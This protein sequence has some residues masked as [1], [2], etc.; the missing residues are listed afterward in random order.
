MRQPIMTTEPSV[1]TTTMSSSPSSSTSFTPSRSISKA[2]I[3][4]FFG[5]ALLVPS[6]ACDQQKP[7]CATGRGAFIARYTFVSGADDCQKLKGEKIGVQT[8]NPKGERD[9]PDL[10]HASIAIQAESLGL[11]VDNATA[12]GVKDDDTSHH[13]YALG[14]FTTP[15]P[16]S[17]ICAVPTLAPA[18]QN[19]PEVKEDPDAEVSAQP[20]TNVVYT[21]SNVRVYVTPAAYGTQ[22]AADLSIETDGAACV[23][24][25]QAMYP[26]VDCSKPSDPSDPKSALV[27]DD[28][29]CAP[30]A[31]PPAHPTGSGINPD[32]PTHCDPD[33]LV[34]VLNSDGLPVLR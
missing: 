33:L 28:T 32:F 15:E 13:A 8:Y 5:M 26:Y 24:K 18:I 12:G 22:L 30:E 25:V 11:L 17:D 6:T 9:N 2:A 3:A 10:D 7:K 31:S 14:S 21:W 4:A 1:E 27:A 23:Y 29:A 20:A 19:L 34:C 16:T